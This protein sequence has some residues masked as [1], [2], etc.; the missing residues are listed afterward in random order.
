MEKQDDGAFWSI[1]AYL[2][3][4][5]IFWGAAGA[6]ADHFLHTHVLMLVG[7]L[8]GMTAGLWLIWIRFIRQ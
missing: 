8:V 5:L 1:V 2:I 7:L 3:S 4:G 6:L